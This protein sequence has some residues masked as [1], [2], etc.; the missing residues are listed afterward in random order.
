MNCCFDA[1]FLLVNVILTLQV[2]CTTCE[3]IKHKD[4][5]MLG[6]IPARQVIVICNTVYADHID[7]PMNNNSFPAHVKAV[8][9]LQCIVYCTYQALGY[10]CVITS[11]ENQLQPVSTAGAGVFSFISMTWCKELLFVFN[12]KTQKHNTF[13]EVTERRSAISNSGE[14]MSPAPPE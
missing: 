6:N 4:L 8:A 12:Q 2:H 14:D 9:W 7:Y 13:K 1:M 5:N 11:R 3:Q 10:S